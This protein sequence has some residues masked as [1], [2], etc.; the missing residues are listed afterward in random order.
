MCERPQ[1][2]MLVWLVCWFWHVGFWVSGVASLGSSMYSP[3]Q[4]TVKTFKI[5]RFKKQTRKIWN[6]KRKK[7]N[8]YGKRDTPI[9][10]RGFVYKK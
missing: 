2:S 1:N 3:S 9:S 7:P 6:P 4:H 10:R 5:Q 8:H